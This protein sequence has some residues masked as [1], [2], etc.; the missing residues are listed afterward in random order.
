M[1]LAVPGESNPDFP[2]DKFPLGQQSIEK[3]K[4]KKLL[5]SLVHVCTSILLVLRLLKITIIITLMIIIIIMIM[6]FFC[7]VSLHESTHS[8]HYK[9]SDDTVQ[10]Y[11]LGGGGDHEL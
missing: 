7:A 11:R 6:F 2:Q 10:T 3:I 5:S 4:K 8:A 1:Q 9:K